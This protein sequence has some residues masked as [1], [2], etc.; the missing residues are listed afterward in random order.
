MGKKKQKKKPQNTEIKMYKISKIEK[1]R[2]LIDK[3][4][5][6]NGRML[7]TNENETRNAGNGRKCG[8]M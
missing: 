1:Q 8:K 7:K 3:K 5:P 4:K 6:K 2:K